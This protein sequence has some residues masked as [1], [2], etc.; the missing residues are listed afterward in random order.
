MVKLKKGGTRKKKGGKAIASGG[1][2]CVFKPA[3][4]CSGE[5]TRA[6]GVSKLMYT[7]YAEQEMN[8]VE[9]F[10]PVIMQI[11]N[12]EQYFI[13]HG[14][15]LC[16]P[17][18]LTKEDLENVEMCNNLKKRDPD[19]LTGDNINRSLGELK[20]MNIPYG[21]Q[22]L[23]KWIKQTSITAD[24]LAKLNVAII[25]LIENAVVPMNKK[26]LF[27][28]D[29]KSQNILIDDNFNLKII[30]WGLAGLQDNN[31][32]PDAIVNRPPQF[33][34]P[35]SNILF[36]ENMQWFL[37]G[38][39]REVLPRVNE[40]I[41][42]KVLKTKY[43]IIAKN[44]I[45]FTNENIGEGHSSLISLLMKD[46]YDDL[47][48]DY[49]DTTKFYENLLVEIIS[50]YLA[51]IFNLYIHD[52]VFQKEA[53]FNQVFANNVD[54]WGTLTIYLDILDKLFAKQFPKKTQLINHIQTIIIKYMYGFSMTHGQT[55]EYYIPELIKDL[56]IINLILGKNP[57]LTKNTTKKI[58]I[59]PKASSRRLSPKLNVPSIVQKT[60][61][62]N[63][64]SS[65]TDS[66][67]SFSWP[68]GKRCPKRTRRN[69]LTLR[70]KKK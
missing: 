8:E 53:Y 66:R 49:T 26:K 35:F 55:G 28:F 13:M 59:T 38:Q 41:D 42:P 30:D 58:K 50:G 15:S 65:L 46:V 64:I 11:P 31:E 44:F 6:N 10:R 16:D 21:G 3:L 1:F 33:N 5:T 2:G 62:S 36:Y 47:L 23:S 45:K 56:R 40:L 69:K 70:C 54:I 4:K 9:R 61:D 17:A 57:K 48:P 24:V 12:H 32:I 37:D 67:K 18:P 60:N 19:I 29:M 14:I 68:A 20:S 25:D 7:N 34:V 22:D 51:D 39:F 52:G 27:H 63:R 43:K